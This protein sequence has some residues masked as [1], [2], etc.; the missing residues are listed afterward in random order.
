MSIK[1]SDFWR[2]HA[3]VSRTHKVCHV[4]HNFFGSF[5]GKV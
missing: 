3:D 1:L 5:L 2:K 4:I